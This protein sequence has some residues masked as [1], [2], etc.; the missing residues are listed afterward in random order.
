M[1][2]IRL[3]DSLNSLIER[4]RFAAKQRG[5]KPKFGKVPKMIFPRSLEREYARR[6]FSLVTL[7]VEQTKKRLLPQLPFLIREFNSNR[8]KIDGADVRLDDDFVSRLKKLIQETQLASDEVFA[9][10]RLTSIAS[11][12]GGVV[13]EFNRKEISRVIAKAVGTD[14]FINEPWLND[15]MQLFVADNVGLIKS[16]ETRYFNDIQNVVMQGAR[17]GIRH[18]EI[19]QQIEDKTGVAE[20]RAKLIARDQ[21]NKFNGQLNSLRQKSLGLSKYIWRTSQDERVRDSHASREGETFSWSDPPSDG[22]PGEAIQCRCWA[23]PVL[24]EDEE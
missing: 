11:G 16:V 14:P 6:I 2:N 23:E 13:S 7:M 1:K 10:Q 8:P 4:R 3:D 17:A 9:E 19:A 12:M 21:V 24:N 5:I 18:E 15:Q 20:S 22:H